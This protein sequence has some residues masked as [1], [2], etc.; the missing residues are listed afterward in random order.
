MRQLPQSLLN[1]SFLIDGL[2]FVRNYFFSSEPLPNT[3]KS[4]HMEKM[5]EALTSF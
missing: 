5:L 2:E 1:D 3:K 4:N